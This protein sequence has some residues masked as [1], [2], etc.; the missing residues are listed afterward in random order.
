[1]TDF[2]KDPTRA[3]PHTDFLIGYSLNIPSVVV[4]L[5]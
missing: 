5:K 2:I 1:M 4:H 3:L